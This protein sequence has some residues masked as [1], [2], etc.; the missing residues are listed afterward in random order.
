MGGENFAP[1]QLDA[2]MGI[3]NAVQEMKFIY[4]MKSSK[5]AAVIK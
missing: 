5:E 3:V 2:L 1:V 4:M